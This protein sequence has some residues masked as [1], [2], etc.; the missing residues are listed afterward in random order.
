MP[1]KNGN[2]KKIFLSNTFNE[3]PVSSHPSFKIL[4]LIVLAIFEDIILIKL[5]LRLTL[6]PPTKEISSFEK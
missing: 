2:C 4:D 1:L 3:Q 5:S 6:I